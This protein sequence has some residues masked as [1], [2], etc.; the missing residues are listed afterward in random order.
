MEGL[1]SAREVPVIGGQS[2]ELCWMVQTCTVHTIVM[3]G[4]GWYCGWHG[5]GHVA[6]WGMDMGAET[7]S[8]LVTE[9]SLEHHLVS[10]FG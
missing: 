6:S 1:Y 10:P 4:T 3:D 2:V 5:Q 8:G 9:G 7:C